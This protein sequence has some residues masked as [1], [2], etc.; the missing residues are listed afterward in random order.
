MEGKERALKSQRSGRTGVK[1][2][3][4]HERTIKS[5][6]SAAV[7]AC[8]R[9]GQLTFEHGVERYFWETSDGWWLL[10]EEESDF[11]KDEATMFQ[12][13]ALDSWVD[14]HHKSDSGSLLRRAVG[15]GRVRGTVTWG[16]MWSKCNVWNYIQIDKIHLAMLKVNLVLTM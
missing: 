11:L 1:L 4:R 16:W 3:L 8:T 2:S 14:R 10:G 6:N 15:L 12:W 5:M 13:M 7:A 9:S